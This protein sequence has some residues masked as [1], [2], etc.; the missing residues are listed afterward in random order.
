MSVS[1]EDEELRGGICVGV[2]EVDDL[3]GEVESEECEE[4]LEFGVLVI[5]LLLL[6]GKRDGEVKSSIE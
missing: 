1:L 2:G 6:V 5:E 4:R 3:F